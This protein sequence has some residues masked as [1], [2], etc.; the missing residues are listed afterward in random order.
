MY[1]VG[2]SAYQHVLKNYVSKHFKCVLFLRGWIPAECFTSSSTVDMTSELIS[3]LE[4]LRWDNDVPACLLCTDHSDSSWNIR[5][6]KHVDPSVCI[7]RVACVKSYYVRPK[8][9]RIVI[10]PRSFNLLHTVETC[11]S[12][13]LK[14]D[15]EF[16]FRS[17][18]QRLLHIDYISVV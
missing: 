4:M 2:I 10:Q 16:C 17:F 6:I 15:S 14:H 9:R 11:F 13:M 3:E 18:M 5:T 7:F 1:C 12:I 8:I